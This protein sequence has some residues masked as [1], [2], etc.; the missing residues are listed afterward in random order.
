VT[1]I[2]RSSGRYRATRTAAEGQQATFTD[3]SR[4]FVLN[5]RK[6]EANPAAGGQQRPV[7]PR[8]QFF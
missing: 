1:D 8:F 2:E 3:A 7:M 6:K 5:V 4:V